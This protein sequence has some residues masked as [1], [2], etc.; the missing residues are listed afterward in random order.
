[1]MLWG[2]GHLMFSQG[3]VSLVLHWDLQSMYSLCVRQL[4]V[5]ASGTGA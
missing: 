3:C 2:W 5:M 4:A 1:M